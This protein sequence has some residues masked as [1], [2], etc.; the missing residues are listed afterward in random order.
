MVRR[1]WPMMILALVASCRPA[2]A[3]PPER[4]ASTEMEVR[5]AGLEGRLLLL[6]QLLAGR[7]APATDGPPL[8]ADSAQR[9]TR[10]EQ[11]VEKVIGFLKQAVRPELDTSQVYAVPI[12]ALDPVIGPSDAAVTLVEVSEFLCPYCNML[13]PTLDQLRVAYPRTLRVVSKYLVI[14]GEPAVA[15]GLAGCAAGRQGKYEA[16]KASLWPAIWPGVGSPDRGEAEPLALEARARSVG[17][18]LKRYRADVATGGPC[19]GWLAT[20]AQALETFGVSGTPTIIINGRVIDQ[21][22]RAGLEAAIDAEL[23][24]VKASGVPAG[25]YYRDVVLAKGRTEAV[26]IS[27]FD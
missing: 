20:G 26:M 3:A 18:D 7:D 22:D 21:R 14:H 24:R 9:V 5:M 4:P 12:D 11:R 25:R 8:P 2:P 23:A 19:E 15:A 17:L 6:E 16:F 1:A 10:V 13:E 27:P